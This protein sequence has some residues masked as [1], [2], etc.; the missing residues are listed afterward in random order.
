MESSKTMM[1]PEPSVAWRPGRPRSERQVELVGPH[2]D[3]GRP[4]EQDGLQRPAGGHAARE[5]QQVAKRRPERHLIDAG[6]STHPQR[7]KSLG[8]VDWAVPMRA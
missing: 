2:E 8:P 6:R 4:A 5:L 1:T 7:Q 3:P